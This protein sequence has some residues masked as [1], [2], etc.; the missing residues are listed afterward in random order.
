MK[1][2]RQLGQ[3]ETLQAQTRQALVLADKARADGDEAKAAEFE[4]TA[5]ALANQLVDRRVQSVEDLKSLHDQSLQAAQQA[6]AGGPGQRDD[7]AG[8][9]DRADQA[10]QPARA[11]QDAGDGRRPPC[12]R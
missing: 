2:D 3:V 9:A 7:A 11:G 10:A 6:R 8:E 4:Q 1:L 12:S 5:Q